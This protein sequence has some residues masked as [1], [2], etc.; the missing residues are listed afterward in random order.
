MSFEFIHE[1]FSVKHL[2]PVCNATFSVM[3]MFSHVFLDKMLM[4][5][6]YI[7]VTVPSYGDR[8]LQSHKSLLMY[9]KKSS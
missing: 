1:F 9:R 8:Q 5:E 6:A 7:C 2:A 3:F 4:L